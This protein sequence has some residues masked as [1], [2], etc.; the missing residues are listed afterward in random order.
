M[1]IAEGLTGETRPGEK[2]K[3]SKPL[4]VAKSVSLADTIEGIINGRRAVFPI[5]VLAK[6]IGRD[7]KP[8]LDG[9]PGT[10][11]DDGK[12]GKDGGDGTDGK[13]ATDGSDGEDGKPGLDGKPG[14]D[15]GDGLDGQ[16]GTD[17]LPGKPGRDGSPGAPGLDGKPGSPGQGAQGR[18]GEPGLI[19]PPG[20]D[21]EGGKRGDQ[22]DKG[23]PGDAAPKFRHKGVGFIAGSITQRMSGIVAPTL[24]DWDTSET[25]DKACFVR[26]N[27]RIHV[28]S[29][30]VYTID[31]HFAVAAPKK[32]D[33][34]LS[35]AV[36][37]S[38]ATDQG[39]GSYPFIR[40][41]D[42]LISAF[43]WVVNLS[44]NDSVSV[45]LTEDG[46]LNSKLTALAG[47]CHIRVTRL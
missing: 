12:P 30:G 16:P 11:G 44:K 26:K 7:G 21:G 46:G 39:Y 47:L 10:D 14:R 24:I 3:A 19:G 1:A 29:D 23:T 35:L 43:R 31:G 22:G 41:G 40:Q 5:S 13:D 36:N 9:K 17:G 25:I 6:E 45:L 32:Y 34:L 38:D 15:G 42:R 8:G 20:M 28:L 33:G 2:A 18:R 4:P 27:K 37:G